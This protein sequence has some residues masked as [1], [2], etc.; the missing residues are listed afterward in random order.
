M[1]NLIKNRRE[2]KNGE[3]ILTFFGYT[4]PLSRFNFA[5]FK[6]GGIEFNSIG[7]Y[8]AYMK[9]YLFKDYKTMNKI[10]QTKKYSEYSKYARDVDGFDKELWA[11]MAPQYMYEGYMARVKF[12][13]NFFEKYFSYFKKLNFFSF[14]NRNH[15][16]LIYLNQKDYI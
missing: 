15:Y 2:M 14:N 6:I 11:N 10:R 9:A 7:K 4:N 1:E 12:F 13:K 16:V 3:K 5:V 8:M